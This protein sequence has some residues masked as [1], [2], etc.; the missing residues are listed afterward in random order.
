VMEVF[1]R[2][3]FAAAAEVGEIAAGDPGVRLR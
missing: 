1:R 3:G 2:H